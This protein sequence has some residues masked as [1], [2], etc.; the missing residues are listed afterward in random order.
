MAEIFPCVTWGERVVT[1]RPHSP[2][3]SSNDSKPYAALVFAFDEDR[4]VLANIRDRGWCVPGGR[5]EPGEK[6]E[7]AARREA[8]EE[9]GLCLGELTPLG[10]TVELPDDGPERVLAIGY[11]A[12]VTGFEPLPPTFESSEIRLARRE[13]IAECY[14][15][16][17]ALMAAMFDYAWGRRPLP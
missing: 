1:F 11:T 7:D 4:I 5:I 14:F 12:R 3:P 8:W 15:R 6:P 17:D 10:Q 13:D 9:A 16:W 2:A